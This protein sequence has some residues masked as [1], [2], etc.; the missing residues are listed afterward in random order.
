MK[1]S[2]VDRFAYQ[3][4]F[5]HRMDVKVKF[6]FA[7]AV[8]LTASFLPG[9]WYLFALELMVLTGIG[10]LAHIPLNFTLKRMLLAL[11]FGGL[12]FISNAFY[13]NTF[14]VSEVIVLI[15][16][17][18]VCILAVFLTVATTPL[19]KLLDASGKRGNPAVLVVMM[20]YRYFFLFFDVL[21]RTLRALRVRGGMRGQ[22][23]I[24]SSARIASNV[25]SRL[26]QRAEK[27][28]MALLVKGS[29]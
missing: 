6:T 5:L 14:S 18:S 13:G 3:D 7:G 15:L 28:Q 10:S 22:A 23:K 2:P 29:G 17:A 25:F 27:I 16:R 8:V 19:Y 1:H 20:I 26:L 12:V 11:P 24:A 21:E 9:S 4:T